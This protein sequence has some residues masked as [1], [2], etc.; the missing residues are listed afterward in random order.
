MR[1]QPCGA[2]L[3][4]RID[5]VL[6]PPGHYVALALDLAMM[7]PAQRDGELVTDLAAERCVKRR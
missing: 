4:H 5:S 1:L 3:R 7:A 6:A 2:G